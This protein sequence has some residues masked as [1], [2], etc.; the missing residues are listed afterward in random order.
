MRRNAS[1][2]LAFA[3]IVSVT[4]LAAC[5]SGTTDASGSA[6]TTAAPGGVDLASVCPA[7]IGI[8][9]DWN[10]ESEHGHLYQMLGTDYTIDANNKSVTGPLMSKGK[11]TGIKV[12]IQSGG[13]AIGFQT[14]SSQLYANPDIIMGYVSTD[15]AISV[16][17]KTPSV[18]V[19]A[20]LEKNPQMIMWDPATYPDVKTIADLGKTKAVVRYFGGA[21]YMDYLTGAGIIPKAQVDGGYDGT[22]ASFVASGG[23]DAQQGFASGEPYIYQNEIKAW[24]KPVAYQLVH[25]AGFPTYAAAMSV[26][27]DKLAELTPCLK[28]LVPVLQQAE[29]D[30]FADPAPAEKLILELVTEYNTGWVYS[31]GVADYSVAT[32]KKDG[33]VGNGA[34]PTIGNFEPDRVQRM[35]DITTPIYAKAGTKI[36]DGLKPTDIYTNDFI[37]PSIGLPAS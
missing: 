19:F 29:V 22:P 16:S 10:P 20:P 30:F 7:T 23:K 31:Q 27:K 9:T 28:K 18:A 5:S 37:D 21:A 35:F 17:A 6:A 25:D 1:S 4:G 36:A 14:V 3:A 15:E 2:V 26:K 13:P 33:L 34:D 8:Q 24:G 32:M 11:D 12:M